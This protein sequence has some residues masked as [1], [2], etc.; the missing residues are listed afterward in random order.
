MVR[1]IRG[2]NIFFVLF[3]IFIHEL[4]V[5]GAFLMLLDGLRCCAGPYC[6][7]RL[8]LALCLWPWPKLL[9][10]LGDAGWEE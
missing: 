3:F 4:E 7:Y 5:M 6:G 9:R 8:G 1:K 2:E 10:G